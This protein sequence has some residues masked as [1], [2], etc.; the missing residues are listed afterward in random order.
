MGHRF[1][2]FACAA[3][4]VC[5]AASAARA[6]IRIKQRMT[7][8][9]H[10][11][12]TDVAIKGRRQRSEM[13]PAPGMRT[14]SITQC[15]MRR[16]LNI[17]DAARKY[18]VT[19]LD[20]GDDAAAAPTA[21][22]VP[23]PAPSGAT[24][25][26]LVTYVQTLTD[27]GERKQL[28]GYTARR[29]KMTTRTEHSP[30]AC[31]KDDTR[32]ESDG[33]YIDL[34]FSFECLT[35]QRPQSPRTMTHA[36]GCQDRMR[37]RTVGT[38]KPGYPV[39]VTTRYFNKDGSVASEMRQEVVSL[40]RAELDPALFD[41]P[42]GYTQAASAQELYDPSAM[43]KAMQAAAGRDD[44]GAGAG[45][46]TADQSEGVGASAGGMSVGATGAKQPGA[47]RVGV[48]R[49]NNRTTQSVDAGNMRAL[50]V[51]SLTGGGVE[52]VA[53]EETTPEGAQAE[54][55]QK[56]CDYVLF[57]DISTLKQSSANKIGGF[58]GRATG[59]TGGGERFEVKLDYTLVPVAGG[60]PAQANVSAKEEGAADASLGA[61]LRKEAQ[62]VVSKVRK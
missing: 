60:A 50:L 24:R 19:P 32:Y 45:T 49:L 51:A 9:G 13:E 18:T 40:T 15:D 46:G 47:I 54:A 27:T 1:F 2:N 37:F 7:V 36:T 25:G 58:L 48:V 14:I 21:G 41:V 4:V 39:D 38:A 35:G 26:G 12:E 3:L 31:D 11:M 8:Q 55:K 22:T 56:E 57:T 17:S 30:D 23:A 33:W 16:M 29:L 52:S 10:S 44:E 62:A 59:V 61:A 53:I 42:A 20:G 5:G 34:E 43:M 28:F 6:D